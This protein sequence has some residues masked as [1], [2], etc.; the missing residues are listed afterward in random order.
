[1]KAKLVKVCMLGMAVSMFAGMGVSVNAADETDEYLA[2]IQGD[3]V[4]LFPELSKEENRATWEKYAAEYVDKDM[5]SDSVDMLLSMCMADIYG[6]EATDAYAEDPDSMRFDC[7]FLGDV[8]EFNVDGNTIS[9]VDENGDEVFS[10]TYKPMDIDNENGFLFYETEDEDAG[11]FQYFA[12]SPDTPETTYHLEFRYADNTDDLQSWFEG[13]YAYWNAAA[14]SKDYDEEMMDNCIEYGYGGPYAEAYNPTSTYNFVDGETPD[15]LPGYEAPTVSPHATNVAGEFTLTPEGG[16]ATNNYEFVMASGILHVKASENQI[17]KI[18]E[19]LTDTTYTLARKTA[20]GRTYIVPKEDKEIQTVKAFETP[21]EDS[22]YTL[23]GDLSSN[24]LGVHSIQANVKDGY[25]WEDGTTRTKIYSYEIYQIIDKP[26]AKEKVEYN[27]KEQYLFED[28]VIEAIESKSE[29]YGVTTYLESSVLND[30]YKA[31]EIGEYKFLLSPGKGY[32]WDETGDRSRLTYNWSIIPVQEKE[33][34]S[35]EVITANLSLKGSDAAAA[36]LSVLQGLV[37]ADGHAYLT[38]PN[39]PTEDSNEDNDPNWV[40]TPPTTPLSDNATLVTYTDGSMAVKVPIRNAVFTLQKLG[41][42]EQVAAEDVV[43]TKRDGK[44]G[45]KT[46]RIDS[47]TIPVTTK[48]GSVVF[49]DS[50]VYPTLLMT[51]YTVP[52]TLTWGTE[53]AQEKTSISSA[54]VTG[55]VD[56]TY[57]GSAIT[58]PNLKVTLGGGL[59]TLTEGTDYTVSYSNNVN[60]GTATITIT[61]IGNYKDSITK[62]FTIKAAQNNGGQNNGTPK[63]ADQNINVKVGS[64]TYKYKNIQKKAANFT[65][66]ASAAGSVSYKVTATPKKGGKYISVNS[67]GKVTLKKKA[68]AGTY[69]IT[70]FATATADKNAASRIVTVN[71]AKSKQTLTAKVSKKTVKA[72]ALKKKAAKVT[73]KAKGKGKLTYKVTATPAGA[74]KYISVTKKGKVTLK[75][76][77]PK[78]TYK[79]QVTAGETSKYAK[80]VKTV[81]ITVK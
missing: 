74:G 8:K 16:N 25:V 50:E 27:G 40:Q 36:G 41:T 44:Y 1:M 81:S 52:L 53:V 9:G 64:K 76:G 78:G 5:V 34:A 31:T 28:D 68:P 70:V 75:K 66:G 35:T 13:N 30:Q 15:T 37:G 42:S 39:A 79:I 48:T 4:E 69:Q 24:V 43:I 45:A 58:Q 49:K 57:T 63:K 6:Q 14:I 38:N 19:I 22:G 61:G 23:S 59:V 7:Y 46:N 65:I 73:I 33:V 77:A 18:P 32:C 10:H 62:T 72:T 47:I 12:F 71:V 51:G 17:V 3:F 54:T 26:V 21:G 20:T 56:A 60:A 29:R 80:A 11:M 67:K 2:Q 55:I